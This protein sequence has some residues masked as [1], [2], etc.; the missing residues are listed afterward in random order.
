MSLPPFYKKYVMIDMTDQTFEVYPIEEKVL[1][2][3]GG[4]KGLGIYL[5][6]LLNPID[7]DPLSADNHLIINVGPAADTKIWGSSR[8]GIYTKSPLTNFFVDSTSG[9]HLA[10]PISKTG[11]DAI[12]IKGSSSNPTFLEIS[13]KGV[14]FHDASD[15]W[16]KDTFDT[17]TAILEKVNIKGA[18]ACVIGP[19]GEKLVRFAQVKNDM[20][21]SIGRG[22]IGAVF[23]S[24]R[25]KGIAFHGETQRIAGN[26]AKMKELFKKYRENS[27][28]DPIVAKY[29]KYG[30]PMGVALLNEF[31]AFPTEYWNKGKLRGFENITAEMM[32]E[33]LE[34]KPKACGQC[35]IAC[36]KLSKTRENSKYP[37]MIMEGPEYETLYAFG[38][39]CCIADMEDIL[40]LNEICDR[41][42][43]DT[44]TA[45]NIVAF[46]ME[47]SKRN[48]MKESFQY[49]SVKDAEKILRLIASC[50]GVG[51]NLRK[52]IVPAAKYYGLEELAIHNK[53]MEPAGYDPRALPGTALGYAVSMRGACHLR[54]GFYKAELSGVSKPDD[55]DGKAALVA[56]WEDRFCAYDT[57]ILCRFFREVYYWD[58]T[59][60]LFQVIYGDDSITKKD[61]IAMSNRIHTLAKLFNIRENPDKATTMDDL[62]KRLFKE[63]L[64]N[65]K[66]MKEAVF[67][68]L[69]K[70][71]YEVRGWNEFG[72][73]NY[74]P[75][76]DPLKIK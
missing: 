54:S 64:E 32:H 13:D 30:T 62:P 45:G 36:S 25:L 17:E 26:D 76:V 3:Y 16:G 19:A 23:G 47:A 31:G 20:W 8:Y 10:K 53:G 15:L 1:R 6:H 52:G 61:L 37:G 44:I 21:R 58:E 24:K 39:L 40:Y 12:V 29:R 28:G 38:G 5:L 49:G 9:G 74:D 57:L 66:V 7:V 63:P 48:V 68:R 72:I 34:V 2:A 14:I 70:E 33:V 69:R 55:F 27:K 43:V 51:L 71:Y 67:N 59:V 75:N 42:G 65:G 56:D 18:G 4:G 41:I 35:F 46:A 11:Y 73:P 50:E 60:E 22:G